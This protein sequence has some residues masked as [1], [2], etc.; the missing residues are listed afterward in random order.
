MDQSSPN[1]PSRIATVGNLAA[2]PPRGAAPSVGSAGTQFKPSDIAHRVVAR[3]NGLD[4][5]RVEMV[6]REPYECRHQG[7]LSHLLIMTERAE[8]VDGESLM[9][10][11]P[12]STR[13]ETSGRLSFVPRG[14]HFSGWAKPR[15]LTRATHF[16][17]DP[18]GPLVDGELRFA[19][20]EFKPRMY[21]RDQALWEICSKLK[22]QLENPTSSKQQYTEALGILLAHELLR[23]NNSLTEKT[24]HVHGGLA[25]WQRTR[26]TEYVEAH[27]AETV[28]LSQL[29]EIAQLSPFH[30]SRAFKQ[31]FGLPPLR[32][33]T[34]RRIERAKTLLAGET[35]ITQVAFTVGFV[36]SSSFTNAF[37][38]HT[39]ATPTVFR[40]GLG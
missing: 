37:H 12:R 14:Y 36:E 40:R 13:R 22:A 25:A 33:V 19:E 39:G 21:F 6:R 23:L 11:L 15:V 5:E 35:S 4:A 8:R 31:S 18:R 24:G 28:R 30:F 17:I 16:Y 3:W 32:Y 1:S 29:A 20:T 10:G 2:E 34:A 38:K 9:D 27:L 26:V 7:G